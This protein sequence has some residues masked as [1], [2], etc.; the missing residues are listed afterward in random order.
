MD[1]IE[2]MKTSLDY[3][4]LLELRQKMQTERKKIYDDKTDKDSIMFGRAP[5][6]N[7]YI[8]RVETRIKVLEHMGYYIKCTPDKKKK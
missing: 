6:L 2:K 3:E 5:D 4:G 7:F 1:L 8:E